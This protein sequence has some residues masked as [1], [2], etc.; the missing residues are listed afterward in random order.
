MSCDTRLRLPVSSYR[1]VLDAKDVT[2]DPTERRHSRRREKNVA[3]LRSRSRRCKPA[4]LGRE[5]QHASLATWIR[6]I[7]VAGSNEVISEM[8]R[9]AAQ[10][11]RSALCSSQDG[12]DAALYE[13]RNAQVPM[14]DRAGNRAMLALPVLAILIYEAVGARRSSIPSSSSPNRLRTFA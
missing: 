8:L 4:A 3:G 9:N 5:R 13:G 1:N 2:M 11:C 7:F 6:A 12:H 10:Q 14:L